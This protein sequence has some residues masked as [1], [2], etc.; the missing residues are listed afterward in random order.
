[1]NKYKLIIPIVLT[2]IIISL[3]PVSS[4]NTGVYVIVENGLPAGTQ[5]TYINN[6]INYTTTNNVVWTNGI[7][8]FYPVYDYTMSVH[9]VGNTYYLNYTQGNAQ[10]FTIQKL[11]PYGV[12]TLL[13]IA[14]I[15]IAV[16]IKRRNNEE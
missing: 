14:P 10:G 7:D 11:I 1:M 8:I 15:A 2:F 13:I 12:I 9:L 4:A 3:L 5:W 16:V 6:G